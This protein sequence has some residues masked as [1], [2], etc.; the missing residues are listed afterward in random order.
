MLWDFKDRHFRRFIIAW[1][2]LLVTV[3][4]TWSWIDPPDIPM[5]TVTVLGGIIG[6]I[7]TVFSFYQTHRHY[8]GRNKNNDKTTG[9]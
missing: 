7:A 5:G 2:M 9:P 6:L 1:A 3:F 4:L 8:D